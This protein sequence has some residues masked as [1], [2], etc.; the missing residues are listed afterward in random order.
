MTWSVSSWNPVVATG[1]R[2]A[3]TVHTIHVN[4]TFCQAEQAHTR[5]HTSHRPGSV[6]KARVL[7][8]RLHTVKEDYQSYHRTTFQSTQQDPYGEQTSCNILMLK[9]AVSYPSHIHTANF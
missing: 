7:A 4:H 9:G 5:L 1:S 6:W 8:Y 2:I 3:L